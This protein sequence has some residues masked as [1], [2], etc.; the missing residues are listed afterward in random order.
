MKPITFEI[1]WFDEPEDTRPGTPGDLTSVRIQDIT[2]VRRQNLT[3]ACI[4]AANQLRLRH[5]TGFVVRK[6]REP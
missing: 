3:L 6:K 2:F 4:Y 5:N 1:L